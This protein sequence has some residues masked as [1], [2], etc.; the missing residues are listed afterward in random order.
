MLKLLYLCRSESSTTWRT[1]TFS[2]ST[3]GMRPETIFGSFLSTVPVETCFSWLNKT[4]SYP[5]R[6]SRSLVETWPKVSTT[7]TSTE[8]STVT[9]SRLMCLS[10]STALS[11]FATLDLRANLLTS[12]KMEEIV[13]RS[14]IR[15]QKEA[16]RGKMEL[17]TTW[18]LSCSMTRVSTVISL[19]CGRLAAYF[20]R[21]PL[22]CLLS[23]QVV[24][25]SSSLRFRRDHTSPFPMQALFSLTYWADFSKKTQ[26]SVFRGSTCASIRSGP[27][28]WTEENCLGSRLSMSTWRSSVTSILNSLPSSKPQ[29]ASSFPTCST[30]SCQSAPMLFA[31]RSA[32]SKTWWRRTQA[33]I[34]KMQTKRMA[35]KMYSWNHTIRS[36]S[37]TQV[38][39]TMRLM[40]RPKISTT[41]RLISEV[42]ATR[43]LSST[44][45]RK[46]R[47]IRL[48]LT[49]SRILIRK[50]SCS[51]RRTR[52]ILAE[53]VSKVA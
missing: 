45:P 42:G 44:R 53:W 21:W 1:D 13:A 22:A 6:R 24:C 51:N 9:W 36:W 34:L 11:N 28:R 38:F 12:L 49:S 14:Q 39:Q 4:K 2:S 52:P 41:S 27:K 3:I 17:L 18:L 25:S 26:S 19:T 46:E 50:S 20:T 8:S 5:R 30:L 29:R 48:Q 16:R 7:C 33:S 23:R 43:M 32:S 35:Q 40:R 10:T 31:S 47:T 15:T 37:L